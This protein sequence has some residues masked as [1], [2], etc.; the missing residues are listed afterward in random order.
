MLTHSKLISVFT[1]LVQICLKFV[2][3]AESFTRLRTAEDEFDPNQL[4]SVTGLPIQLHSLET[5]ELLCT[6]LSDAFM[7]EI[8]TMM[9]I[10]QVLGV[11][12]TPRLVNLLTQIDFNGYYLNLAPQLNFQQPIVPV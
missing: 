6:Q 3:L 2:E 5:T 12:E 4:S 8:Q 9:D 11:A 1:S 10:L 7:S